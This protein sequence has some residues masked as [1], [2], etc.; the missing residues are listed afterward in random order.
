[1]MKLFLTLFALILSGAFTPALAQ[2]EPRELTLDEQLGL[3]K[4]KEREETPEETKT[5]LANHYYKSCIANPTPA[6]PASAQETLCACASVGMKSK[7]TAK[8]IE[9]L[10]TQ[11]PKSAD[12]R[13]E[14]LSEI[15]GNCLKYPMREFILDD[16]MSNKKFRREVPQYKQVC[17][18]AADTTG[19][20][21]NQMGPGLVRSALRVDWDNPDPLM[22]IIT[23]KEFGRITNGY[24]RRCVQIH[25]FGLR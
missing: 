21:F 8:E 18:C 16:C 13:R 22:E 5:R 9:G 6:L 15:Y 12:Y 4:P 1:M 10:Y 11:V 2:F 19:R 20:Y 17:E 7:M 24:I 25:V 14:F 23:R 3:D